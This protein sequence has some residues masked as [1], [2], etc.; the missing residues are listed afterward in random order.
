MYRWIPY[1]FVRIAILYGAGIILGI[2]FPNRIHTTTIVLALVLLVTGFIACVIRRRG[3]SLLAGLLAALALIWAGMLN[4][5]LTDESSD[6]HH[7]THLTHTVS[8]FRVVVHSAAQDRPRTCKYEVAVDEVLVNGSWRPAF[9][10]ALLYIKKDSLSRRYEYGDVLLV[11]GSPRRIAAPQNPGEFDMRKFQSYRQVYFQS[12]T[13]PRHVQQVGHAP[14]SR[15]K[16]WAITA[17]LWAE[18]VI[19]KYIKGERENAIAS[20]FVLGVTDGLDNDLMNAYAA[21]GAMH[22]L[23]VSGLHV[24]IVYWLLMLIFKPLAGDRTRWLLL[25]V[26]LVVLW[27]YAFVT[28]ISASVLRAVVMFSFAAIARAWNYKM[29]VYNILAA[30]ACLLLVLDPFMILSVG[31]QLSFV[32]VVGIVAIQ[33]ALY[34]LWEPTGWL[35]DEIWKVCAVS[36]AAQIATLP[37]CLYY[38]H[39]FPNYF[40]LTNLFIVPG[41]F[42]VL[43]LGIFLLALSLVDTAAHLVGWLLERLIELLNVLIF[44]VERLPW[45]VIGNIFITPLQCGILAALLLVVWIWVEGRSR[46]SLAAGLMLCAAFSMA[47]WVHTFESRSP[48]IAVYAVPGS[49]AV[50]LIANNVT[51][52]IGSPDLPNHL[53]QLGPN[54]IA[55]R[56]ADRVVSLEGVPVQ[57]GCDL[58]VW[59]GHRIVRVHSPIHDLADSCGA[60]LVI[61]SNNAVTDLRRFSRSVVA[62]CYVIDSSNDRAAT[63]QLIQQAEQLPLRLHSVLQQGALDLR[64]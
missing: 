20:A 60:D 33:P 14:P 1:A 46:T 26:S 54:R 12:I 58:Y 48:R 39:Q 29:N 8:G 28:G 50:D 57:P 45:S 51:S 9:S 59:Q 44:A 31:F 21:T 55:L 7:L 2:Q 40:L 4:V 16:E 56:G 10:R 25:T 63:A 15:V 62:K 37:L 22:V 49:T 23:S 5:C 43:I 42:L 61:I 11:Q 41:S 47:S 34:R 64:L 53:R 18:G 36:I 24:G 27:S 13:S 17:R 35:W 52:Y 3:K 32:A 19:G 30:T 38:F 6:E